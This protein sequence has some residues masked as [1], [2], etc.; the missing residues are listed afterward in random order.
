MSSVKILH[1]NPRRSLG[2]GR[3]G[4]LVPVGPRP[5]NFGDLL[6]PL[7]VKLLLAQ[8]GIPNRARE[9]KTRVLTVGSILHFAKSG[10][11]VWGSGRNGNIPDSQHSFEQLD[12]RAVR[13][14]LT[15]EFLIDRGVPAPRIFG[16]PALLLPQLHPMMTTWAQEKET[17]IS[18]VPNLH[19]IKAF[20]KVPGF[21]SPTAP[22]E[23]VLERIA[24]SRF[25]VGSSLHG[26]IV[27]ESLGIPA[28]LIVPSKEGRFKYEDY[29]RGTGRSRYEPAVDVHQ[30]MKMGGEPLPEW[31]PAP[32]VESFPW[33][34]WQPKGA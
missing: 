2:D 5:N 24:R 34:L 3:L 19:D 20:R 28:R 32:L 27:A 29:Y 10:D 18:V 12:V 16:D 21:V 30:A 13:G 4:R 17:D 31:D 22:L 15:R 33:D 1:W 8:R 14:P 7:I 6:G 25:V 11:H 26:I 9:R 23:L